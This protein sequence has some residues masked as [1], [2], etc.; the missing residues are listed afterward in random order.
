MSCEIKLT[1]IKLKDQK[2]SFSSEEEFDIWLYQNRNEISELV[3]NPKSKSA[4]FSIDAD[5]VTIRKS[6]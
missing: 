2:N 6:A 5:P 1:N 4:T 3:K